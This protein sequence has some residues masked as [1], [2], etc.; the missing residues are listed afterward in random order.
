MTVFASSSYCIAQ[1]AFRLIFNAFPK[2]SFTC[3]GFDQTIPS[4]DWVI[5]PLSP[6][7]INLLLRQMT[8]FQFCVPIC[9]GESQSLDETIYPSFPTATIVPS[10][11]TATRVKVFVSDISA[12]LDQPK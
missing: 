5:K 7:A 4:A 9:F 12:L 3:S 1:R 2:A 6:I 11:E 8:S 10:L